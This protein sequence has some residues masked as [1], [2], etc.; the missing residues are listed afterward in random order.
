MILAMDILRWVTVKALEGRTYAE[1]RVYDSSAM[2]ADL[3]IKE[4]TAPFISVYTDD[5][6]IELD[7]NSAL[8]GTAQVFL[9][10]EAAVG[11]PLAA[12]AA[13][14][15]VPAARALK[16]TDEGLEAAIGFIGRQVT[17]A[18]AATDSPW[19]ELWRML[20]PR[21]TKIEIRRGGYGQDQKVYEAQ[22]FASRIM[23]LT[24]EVCIEPVWGEGIEEGS[25]WDRFL[26]LCVGTNLAELATAVR[27]NFVMD[28]PPPS[29]EVV[30]K[31][32]MLTREGVDALGIAPAL[33]DPDAPES[34]AP[35]L[36]EIDA[37]MKIIDEDT[38]Q[39]LVVNDALA[40]INP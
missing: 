37:R 33:P 2:P 1:M 9:L 3:K 40:A 6:D 27:D 8:N 30:R 22:R 5:A 24:C 13:G 32:L 18:L 7:D 39:T 36:T 19:A 29:W 35:E 17:Q 16:A 31:I 25:V 34:E 12:A 23:R 38:G 28:T 4:E 26:T 20:V 21:R 15:T 14:E 11:G 10:I